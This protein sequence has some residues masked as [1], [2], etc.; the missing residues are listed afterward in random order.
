MQELSIRRALDENTHK[1]GVLI[2]ADGESRVFALHIT[3][4]G[5][6]IVTDHA[7]Y[8]KIY[9]IQTLEYFNMLAQ[10]ETN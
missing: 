10:A 2:Y 7:D 3:G 6:V 1:Q 5:E 8:T 9:S 4:K